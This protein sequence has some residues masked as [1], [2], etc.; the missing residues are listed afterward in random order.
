[1]K[2]REILNSALALAA[3]AVVIAWSP[4]VRAEAPA[5][6]QTPAQKTTVQLPTLIAFDMTAEKGVD[7]S[8]ANLLTEIVIDRITKMGKY[9]VMGQKDL[10]KLLAWEQ[11]KQMKGCTDSGCMVKIA[12]AMGANFITEGSVGAIGDQYIVTL[13]LID[14]GTVN[15][16]NRATEMVA[17]D[18]NTLV[19]SIAKIVDLVLLGKSGEAKP[20]G[21]AQAKV[22]SAPSG[23]M[24]KAGMGCLF[25]GLGVVAI[26]GLFSGLA[27]KT[28]NEYNSTTNPAELDNLKSKAETYY[29]VSIASYA[30]GGAAAVTGAVLWTYDALAKPSDKKVEKRVSFN[31]AP[32]LS[33]GTTGIVI[34]GNW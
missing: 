33:I 1:M 12:G 16:I 13:K 26:G 18:E 19:R 31:A 22:E 5:G 4:G 27:V 21:E 24:T 3:A 28:G 17:R 30:I 14:T 34:S 25:G 6:S 29:K 11:S 9:N 32:L 7:P 10:E 15:V 2:N 20:S 8:V 23:V